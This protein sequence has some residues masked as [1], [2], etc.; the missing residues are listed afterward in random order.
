MTDR[1]L[2]VRSLFVV[3]IIFVVWYRDVLDHYLIREIRGCGQTCVSIKN[4][5]IEVGYIGW[6]GGW[7]FNTLIRE[8]NASDA[9]DVV[10]V[11]SLGGD[12]GA[13]MRMVGAIP[14][15]VPL[16]AAEIAAL[17]GAYLRL[18]SGLGAPGDQ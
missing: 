8:Q 17:G 16:T 14:I 9:P 18:E 2:F 6:R 10:R 13:G 15:D 7:A 12:F 4:D 1:Q 11:D 5:R 3:T